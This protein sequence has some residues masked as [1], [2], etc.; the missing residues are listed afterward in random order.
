MN[1]TFTHNINVCFPPTQ[2]FVHRQTTLHLV[3]ATSFLKLRKKPQKWQTW[4]MNGHA[5]PTC[6]QSA[7]S[8][9]LLW[10]IPKGLEWIIT[11]DLFK[12][13]KI[14]T[15]WINYSVFNAPFLFLFRTISLPSWNYNYPQPTL[16]IIPTAL[17]SII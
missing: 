13:T 2:L 3:D 7:L 15:Q 11:Q 10:M 6:L 5:F 14:K 1:T 8:S 17:L 12:E 4:K 9:V 16:S